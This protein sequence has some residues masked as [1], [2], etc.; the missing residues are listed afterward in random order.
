M[1]NEIITGENALDAGAQE[2]GIIGDARDA[3]AESVDRKAEFERLITEK[4]KDLYDAK[5]SD[6]VRR[7]VKTLRETADRYRRMTPMLETLSERYGI[8]AD[9][10]EGLTEAISSDTV[11]EEKM[12]AAIKAAAGELEAKLT[13]KILSEGMRPKENGLAGN[14]SQGAAK[15]VELLTKAERNDIVKRVARG[16]K[17]TL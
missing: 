3:E 9:D 7:R 14:S 17:I 6:T 13:N 10:I 4:F 1:E 15:G 2:I 12:R 11:S 8:S 16:E 5:V